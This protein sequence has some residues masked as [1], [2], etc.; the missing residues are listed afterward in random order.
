MNSSISESTMTLLDSLHPFPG[1]SGTCYVI[2]EEDSDGMEVDDSENEQ[3][4]E[5]RTS[6]NYEQITKFSR[7]LN[8]CGN[9]LDNETMSNDAV[10]YKN[11]PSDLFNLNESQKENFDSIS[12]GIILSTSR[13]TTTTSSSSCGRLSHFSQGKAVR[14]SESQEVTS[15]GHHLKKGHL[16]M[17]LSSRCRNFVQKQYVPLSNVISQTPLLTRVRVIVQIHGRGHDKYVIISGTRRERTPQPHVVKLRHC[18]V[19]QSAANPSCFTVVID[20]AEGKS[21]TFEATSPDAALEWMKAFSSNSSSF[22]EAA[23]R[24]SSQMA[25]QQ[26]GSDNVLTGEERKISSQ[27]TNLQYHHQMPALS[28]SADEED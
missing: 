17:L 11:L 27:F 8:I 12:R 14:T 5:V 9:A 24:G 3:L 1:R 22:Q 25:L 13:E 2:Q 20:G 23:T 19:T 10:R 21:F 7:D 28:E 15:N 4:N 16:V 18:H 26:A 6:S